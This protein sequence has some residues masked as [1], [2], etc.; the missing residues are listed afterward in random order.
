L[1]Q[2]AWFDIGIRDLMP[3]SM[4]LVLKVLNVDP[5]KGMRAIAPGVPSF[6]MEQRLHV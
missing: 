2:H 3:T 1:S 6:S 5:T 4:M